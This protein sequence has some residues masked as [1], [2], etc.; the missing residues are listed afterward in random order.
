MALLLLICLTVAVLPIDWPAPPFDLGPSGSAALT[1]GLTAALLVLARVF[2]ALTVRRLARDPG[3]RETASR[4]H[5]LLRTAYFFLNLAGLGVVLVLCGWGWTVKELLTVR[6]LLLPGAEFL[7]LAPYLIAMLGSWALFYDAERA[8]HLAHPDPSVRNE[9]WSRR[10]YVVF[11]LRHHLLMVFLPVLLVITQ[12][13]TLRVYP[14]LLDHTWAK[15]AAFAA[16]FLVI[17]FIPSLVPIVLGLKRMPASPLRD[18]LEA[19]AR[20]LGVRYRHLYIWD[21]RGNLAT[22]MVTG[23][24]PRFR[25]IVFTDLLLQTL[26]EDEIEAVFGH[27]VGHVRHGHLLYYAIFLLLS[28]LTLGAGYR[29]VELAL[30]RSLLP[31]DVLLVLSVVTTGVYLFLVFGFLSRRCERQADVFG[32]KAVSC[33]SPECEAHNPE[34]PLAARGRGLCR[35]GIGTFVRALERVEEINGMARG[36]VAA[37]RRGLF[38]RVAGLLRFV[39]VWLGTWQHSTIAKRVDFLKSLAADPRRERGFQWRVAALR[40]GLLFVLAGSVIAVAG[41][42]G[43]RTL[44]DGI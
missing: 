37:A 18:R 21:T 41:W 32:C 25:Q 5:A 33:T 8:L 22:A 44:L 28:F 29:A 23:L 7:T 20:R 1:G 43:W 17:L 14:Q 27:E 30:G 6:D 40:W 16:L 31:D 19:T 4:T 15:L 9:F 42:N 26:T 24:V 13:G 3:S 2:S 36:S 34:T 11:L 38:G 35:T 12:L 10:G 39:G